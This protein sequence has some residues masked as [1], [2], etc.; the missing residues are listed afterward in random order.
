MPLVPFCSPLLGMGQR[1]TGGFFVFLKGG[2]NNMSRQELLKPTDYMEGEGDYM[3][4]KVDAARLWDGLNRF[5]EQ[6]PDL[7]T[8]STLENGGAYIVTQDTNR[9][10]ARL[11][12]S[13]SP[14]AVRAFN[15]GVIDALKPSFGPNQIVVVEEEPFYQQLTK[16]L[17][18]FV[19]A[20]TAQK[21]EVVLVD[22]FM[23]TDSTDTSAY[24]TLSIGR[25]TTPDGEILGMRPGDP[26]IEIQLSK[27]AARLA[28]KGI[29]NIMI[30]D[31]GL[32][33]IDALLP[34]KEI[35]QT[36]GLTIVDFLAGVMPYS[37]IDDEWNTKLEAELL[38]GKQMDFVLPVNSPLDW[39]CQRDFMIFG[40]KT[41][42]M[43]DSQYPLTAPYFYPFTEGK[44]ASI[45]LE[46]LRSVSE[47]LLKA[48]IA[49]IDAINE[50]RPTPLT[51]IDVL[52]GGYG[53]P[54]SVIGAIRTPSPE[55]SVS[56]FLK[57]ALSSL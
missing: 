41:V 43:P 56:E 16:Q 44:S 26:D 33:T 40:G 9:V 20:S 30:A 12:V 14:E 5:I 32:S 23:N 28:K 10:L 22:R 21:A 35:A 49:L 3:M 46:N 45:P 29:T 38:I 37:E 13:I 24:S 53:L 2:E 6:Q 7:G 15:A 34:Y 47:S 54:T 31:D 8:A 18:E 27:L 25:V 50:T 51:F 42:N 57:E 36:Y 48:N 39:I 52:R 4:I 17:D 11:G 19:R 1:G 55:E